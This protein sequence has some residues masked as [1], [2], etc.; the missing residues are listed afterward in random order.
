MFKFVSFLS[1]LFLSVNALAIDTARCPETID[2]QVEVQ[3]VYKSSIYKNFPGWKEAQATLLNN[4]VVEANFVLVSTKNNAC[5]YK[6]DAQNV[7]KLSTATFQD[8]ETVGEDHVDQLIL[9]LKLENSSY[10]SYIPVKGYE[11]S[12]V[13]LYQNPYSLK[14]KAHLYNSTQK[15]Y[16]DLDLGMVSVSGK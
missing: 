13:E 4:P 11:V 14:I 3:R 10:V 5:L 12:G 8:P 15:R 6:D 9:N 7:A 2:V 1:V 16:V